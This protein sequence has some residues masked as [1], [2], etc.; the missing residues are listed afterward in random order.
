MFFRKST[1]YGYR[2]GDL[3]DEFTWGVHADADGNEIGCYD[4][5]DPQSS[6]DIEN[7]SSQTTDLDFEPLNHDFG[8]LYNYYAVQDRR[9]LC[10]SGWHPSS[11]EDWWALEQSVG[12][13]FPSGGV[14]LEWRGPGGHKLKKWDPIWEVNWGNN[15]SGFSGMPGGLRTSEDS[16]TSGWD[17]WDFWAPHRGLNDNYHRILHYAEDLVGRR[18]EEQAILITLFSVR[19][20]QNDGDVW[21]SCHVEGGRN[22]GLS[23]INTVVFGNPFV[24]LKLPSQ[25]VDF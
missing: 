21:G 2:N 8:R 18:P 25:K 11:E 3:I 13:T 1:D 6:I 15:L 4:T 19:C 5:Y 23:P 14:G 20:V 9:E 12:M 24:V 22:Q 7:C 10:P 16:H 17:V